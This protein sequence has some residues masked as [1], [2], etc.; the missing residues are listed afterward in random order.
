MIV[1]DAV[2]MVE[3]LRLKLGTKEAFG[4]VTWEIGS[5]TI[6]GSSCGGSAVTNLTNIQDAG[7]IPGLMP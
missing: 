3:Q 5:E 6:G 2:E 7:S 1:S 4:G